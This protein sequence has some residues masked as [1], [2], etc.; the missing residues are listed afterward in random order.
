MLSISKPM[1][2][3]GGHIRSPKR[4]LVLVLYGGGNGVLCTSTAWI[5]TQLTQGGNMQHR[6][7]FRARRRASEHTKHRVQRPVISDLRVTTGHILRT[8]QHTLSV[9]IWTRAVSQRLM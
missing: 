9:R 5:W 7:E 2:L 4:R 1:N 6:L 3:R 8:E